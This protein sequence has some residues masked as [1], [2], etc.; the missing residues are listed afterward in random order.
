[1]NRSEHCDEIHVKALTSKSN[2][3]WENAVSQTQYGSWMLQVMGSWL[4]TKD[5]SMSIPTPFTSELPP[6]PPPQVL[7]MSD[8]WMIQVLTRK[9]EL[10]LSDILTCLNH[11]T[12]WD[13]ASTH[14]LLVDTRCTCSPSY[15]TYYKQ[16]PLLSKH[17]NVVVRVNRRGVAHGLSIVSRRR[18]ARGTVPL[19][20]SPNSLRIRCHK[21]SKSQ[22]WF[23]SYHVSGIL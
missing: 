2:S 10:W 9:S 21:P 3:T 1:M 16:T 14:L 15:T 7:N 12:S 18:Q 5:L 6:P 4:H 13:L 23:W 19:E 17:L 8:F 20:R 11:Y 22:C